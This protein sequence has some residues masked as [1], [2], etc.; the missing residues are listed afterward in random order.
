MAKGKFQRVEKVSTG[1]KIGR[2][3]LIIILV[4][5]L[6]LGA[7]VAFVFSKLGKITYDD[8]VVNETYSAQE[9]EYENAD[10]PTDVVEPT[11]D[12]TG[13]AA[14]PAG[15]TEE[16]VF[17]T[18]AEEEEGV[19]MEGLEMVTAPNLSTGEL[20]SDK[21]VMNILLLG[22]DERQAQFNT[23]SRSDV[24]ILVSINKKAG[25]VKL[26]SFSRGIAAPFMEGQYKGK[27]EWLT[28][29]HRWGGANMVMLALEECFKV[30]CDYFV[31][32]N[33]QTVKT[34]VDAIG[35]ID[36][37]LTKKE[38]DYLNW[39]NNKVKN[40]ASTTTQKPCVEGMNNLDG[41]MACHYARLRAVDDDWVRMDRQR[42]VILAAVD[43]MKGSDLMTLNNL[44]DLALPYVQT[45]M[46]T[47]E[48]AKLIMYAPKFL[49]SDFDQLEIPIKNSYKGMTVM[50]GAGGWALDYNKN[51]AAL[52][53]FLYGTTDGGNG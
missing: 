48:I 20:V 21:D 25:T 17:A 50:S 3:A 14:D 23:N 2:A 1:K 8:G 45:N 5:A 7:V 49:D 40:M 24:I 44:A 16:V 18:E 6:L 27:Y 47:L 11:V 51:N 9:T 39:F 29:L 37:N 34:V 30:E 13:E 53:E 35:G 26:V 31:R 46:S 33:F 38:A 19:N 41:G 32:V 12:A 15:A 36:M 42:A 10:D 4:I 28:N 43:K 52:H 22:T